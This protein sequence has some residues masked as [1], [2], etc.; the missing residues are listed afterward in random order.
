MGR[1]S[2]NESE[3]RGESRTFTRVPFHHRVRLAGKNAPCA[4]TVYEVSRGGLS[5]SMR[6]YIRPG[7]IVRVTFEDITYGA[8]P[9]EFDARVAWCEAQGEPNGAE[10]HA[11]LNTLHGDPE[12]LAAMSEIFYTALT[13]LAARSRESAV[14][15]P[16]PSLAC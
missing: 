13:R 8:T 14:A 9:A 7:T 2:C 15:Q 1:E 5:M 10:Y 3:E 11:G 4:A 12:T 6:A 16:C